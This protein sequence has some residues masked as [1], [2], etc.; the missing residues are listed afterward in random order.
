MTTTALSNKTRLNLRLLMIALVLAIMPVAAFAN[1]G[2]PE[3]LDYTTSAS[4]DSSYAPIALR[5][6]DQPSCTDSV[7]QQNS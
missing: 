5:P 6:E 1:C 3:N 2:T 7:V 4:S